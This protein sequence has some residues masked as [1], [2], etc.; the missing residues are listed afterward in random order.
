[1]RACRQRATCRTTPMSA[2]PASPTWPR[3][4]SAMPLPGD[5]A[6]MARFT[7]QISHE[8]ERMITCAAAGPPARVAACCGV[9]G[10]AG[11][12]VMRRALSEAD[13]A[14]LMAMRHDHGARLRE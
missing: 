14:H 13:R 12:P 8:G 6:L 9:R 4:P 5:V 10:R 2:A 11:W 7:D 1:M 3:A